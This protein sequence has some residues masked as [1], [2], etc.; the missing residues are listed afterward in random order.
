MRFAFSFELNFDLQR[1]Y[2]HASSVEVH[3][4]ARYSLLKL[5]K[6]FVAIFLVAIHLYESTDPK[7]RNINLRC[8]IQMKEKSPLR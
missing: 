5:T 1:F 3:F 4:P 2:P 8:K 7:A 6:R